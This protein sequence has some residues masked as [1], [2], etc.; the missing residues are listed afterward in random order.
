M[1]DEGHK[2][3]SHSS[4]LRFAFFAQ[5]T[6]I[7]V[8]SLA[9][10]AGGASLGS[11]I[12]C[13]SIRSSIQ[14]EHSSNSCNPPST[15]LTNSAE[16]TRPARFTVM[17]PTDVPDRRSCFPITCASVVLGMAQYSRMTLNAKAF[18]RVLRSCKFS[19]FILPPSSFILHPSSFILP[20]SSF[21]FS[22]TA[23]I[24]QGPSGPGDRSTPSL[25][26]P[27]RR[28]SFAGS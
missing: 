17:S 1:K 27:D 18:V 20:P 10:P 9:S 26:S 3:S 5:V 28:R 14:Y 21:R 22:G 12:I 4:S 15:L 13:D 19:S 8:N 7:A 24:W 2:E 23:A 6:R 25:N 11:G 16:E